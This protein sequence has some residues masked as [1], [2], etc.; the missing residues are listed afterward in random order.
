[1]RRLLVAALPLALLTAGFAVAAQGGHGRIR[2]LHLVTVV[3]GLTEPLHVAAP[4]NELN[5]IYIVEKGGRIRV[6][7]RGQLRARPFL[8]ISSLV[9]NGGEQGLLSVAFHPRY[10]RNHL[11]YVYY[12]DTH[13]DIR[14]IEYWS[15]G[16]N[17]APRR[18][19]QILFVK[20]QPYRNHNGGQLAFGPDGNLYAGTGDGGSAGD[21][22]N[23]AQDLRSR[24][25]KLLK[26]NVGKRRPVP[27]IAGYGLRN[28][29]RFSFDRLTGDLYIGDVGQD[30][31]EELDYT[32]RNSPELENYGWRVYEGKAHYT[33]E[34]PNKAGH[35]VF[36]YVVLPNPPNCAVIGGFVYRGKSIPEAQGRYFFGDNCNSRI[37]SVTASGGTKVRDEPFTVDGLASFGE[38]ARGELYLA[39]I[40]G[41]VVYR[42]A[43]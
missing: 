36:P 24:L 27:Q 29:W 3:S 42:L 31:W 14:V 6:R 21:P 16:L 18:S 33:N 40:T 30:S 5:N 11:F 22:Q 26:I 37:R 17:R 28:P 8:D 12:T 15:R 35:L 10:A 43:G 41:G 13:G 19:R 2:Q 34:K 7:V 4:R 23:H 9:S 39:S 38:D 1:M 25:G 32:P 20:H